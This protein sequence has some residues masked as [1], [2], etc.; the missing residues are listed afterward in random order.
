MDEH[1]P[2]NWNEIAQGNK[3]AANWNCQFCGR[4]CRLPGESLEAFITRTNYDG[5]AVKG[6]PR[7]WILTTAHL[8]HDPGNPK[9]RLAALCVPCHRAY[10]NRHMGTIKR[11]KRER[12]GQMTLADIDIP[13]WGQ[14]LALGDLT[15]PYNIVNRVSSRN[16]Q[17]NKQSRQKSVQRPKSHSK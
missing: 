2:I 8:D 15:Q 4:Q 10:D 3:Q 16:K 14:Q 12:Y 7:R 5:P 9:A 6:H 17:D 11:L 1:Y 13:L